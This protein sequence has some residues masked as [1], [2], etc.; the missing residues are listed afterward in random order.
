MMDIENNNNDDIISIDIQNLSKTFEDGKIVALKNVSLNFEGGI[1]HGIIGPA[2]SG[3]TTL[4]RIMLDLMMKDEGDIKYKNNDK[5]VD[6]QDIRNKIAYM[7][8]QQSLYSDLSIREHLEFFSS[9]YSMGHEE[10]IKKSRE[11]LEMTRLDKFIDRPAGKLSGGMY[12]KLGLMCSLLRSPKLVLLDE[13]TNGVDPISRREFWDILN[14][15]VSNNITVIMTTSY[16]DEAER[17][18]KTHLME[19]GN[20]LGT[21]EP[22]SLLSHENVEN[23]DEYFIKRNRNYAG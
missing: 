11:L 4:L 12:K 13:P 20:V 22:K 19:D 10:Y 21:G 23:F 15:T 2:G 6:F 5:Y 16:M 3:K 7:P 17:C 1:L 18:H 9:M 14:N 8:E